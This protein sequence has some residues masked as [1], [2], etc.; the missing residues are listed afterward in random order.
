M[1]PY[2]G[3]QIERD[4][5]ITEMKMIDVDAKLILDRDKCTGCGV[6]IT[7]CPKEAIRRGPVGA[8]DKELSDVPVA[9]VD[10]NKCSFCG[11]CVHLCPFGALELRINDEPK[12]LI[13]EGGALPSLKY[14]EVRLARDEGKTA[15]KFFEG[16]LIAH[17]E[18]CP[19]GCA[20]CTLI[21]PTGA[22]TIPKRENPW[23][24]PPKIEVDQDKCILC[25]LCVNGCPGEGALELVRTKVLYEGDHTDLWDKIVEKLTTKRIS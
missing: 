5:I 10:E 11:V 4:K 1:Y 24:K 14:Q 12:L 23:D 17:P 9:L 13:V 25:G 18:N 15:K 19:G 6:C 3:Q 2:Y 7:V 22:I 8:T 20:T 16:E 21:C